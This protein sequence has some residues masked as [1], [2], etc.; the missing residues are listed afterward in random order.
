MST[1][2]LSFGLV[3]SALAAG[4]LYAEEK[5]AFSAGQIDF[6]EKKIRPV[7][8]KQCY[9]C[10]SETE[11]VKGGLLLDSR[12]GVRQG[13]ETGPALVLGKPDQSLLIQAIRYSDEDLQ[14]PPKHRLTPEQVKDFEEWVKMGAP[15][16]REGKVPAKEGIDYADARKLWSFQPLQNTPVPAVKEAGWPRGDLDRFI[17]ARLDERGLRPNRDA[18]KRTLL[19]RATYNLTGLPPT[20][21]ETREFLADQSPEAFA[22]VVERLL[23]SPAYGEKWGRHWLDVVRYADTSGCNS[24]FP[25]PSAYRYRNYVVEAFNRDLP[26]DEFLREQIA[27][28]LLP[29][30]NDEEHFRKIIGTGYL[31]IARRFGSRAKEF[32]LTLED[33]LDNL[34]KATL[35]LSLGC[36]RC[37]DHKFDPI[38]TGDYYAL[39]GIFESSRFAFPGTEIYR[40]TKDFTPLVPE[41]EA[42]KFLAEAR[43]A[44]ELDDKI[45]NLKNEKKRL[46]REEKKA[47]EEATPKLSEAAAV[48]LVDAKDPAKP[49]RTAVDAEQDLEAARARQEELEKTADRVPK[50]YSVM[51]GTGRNAAVQKKG[52]PA[53]KGEEVP[54]GFLTVLGGQKVPAEEL[55][56]GRRQLAAWITAP[57]NPLTARVMVNRIW[58]H[59]FGKGIVKTPNDFGMRGEAPTHPELLDWLAHRFIE[60]GWSIK[61]MHRLIMLSRTYAL[62]SEENPACSAVDAANT[63]LW[64]FERRRLDAEEVRDSFLAVAGTLDRAPGGSHPFPPEGSWRYTQHK[65]FIADFPTQKRAIYLLQQRIRKQP[66]LEIFDGA[67]A[68]ATT[69]VR[70]VS[71]TPIQ[72]LWLMNAELAHAESMNFAERCMAAFSDEPARISHA[73]ELALARPAEPDE[74]I[75]TQEYLREMTATLNEMQFPPEQHA[76]MAFASFGRVLLSSNEFLF[77][78]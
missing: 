15:D 65:P 32:H 64:R 36:A 17:L 7:L 19:R 43:E 33:L 49:K 47:A 57:S 4:I 75:E 12:A 41:P 3:L 69:A 54:R 51:D 68:N 53:A 78:D 25:I 66:F 42:S 77:L 40:H 11:K 26:Y 46:A 10:H 30:A 72:A 18:D 59:H 56:S 1:R 63:F 8:V 22:K 31:A 70:P 6:F 44:A 61:A 5:P 23:A 39:Y 50:A 76:T 9:K 29:A 37:H 45:E 34:G 67:D 71:H 55:G 16:P 28:D 58:Q 27:G 24:D 38:P 21:E 20:I 62:S 60:S 73:F 74:I 2:S 13:G 35:G 48:Q 52:D 14:M